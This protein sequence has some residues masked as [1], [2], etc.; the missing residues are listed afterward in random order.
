MNAPL[1]YNI[2]SWEQLTKC[3][4]NNS[5]KLSISVTDFMQGE[6]LHGLLIKVQH[7]ML[8]TLFACL[9]NGSGTLLS[10][11]AENHLHQFTTEEIL[12][13]LHK[14]GF[15]VTYN[16]RKHLSGEQ[17]QYLMTLNQLGF[18]KIRTLTVNKYNGMGLTEPTP[19]VVAFRVSQC[20]KWIDNTFVESESGFML[21]L[22]HGDA[23]NISAISK[24]KGF[25]W[26]WLDYVANIDDIINDNM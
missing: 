16:P 25:T 21:A 23:I 19:T 15:Y 2:S 12:K 5:R 11:D 6:Q 7:S 17:L 8:G 20:S 3:Q 24:E 14:F 4:S 1:Q 10:E 22:S 9:V 13:E 18:D 26:T